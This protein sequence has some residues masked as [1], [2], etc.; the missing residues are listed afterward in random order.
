MDLVQLFRPITKWGGMIT[1]D[2]AVPEMVR[3]AFKQARTERPGAAFLILPEDVSEQETDG[4]P[5]RVNVP[6]DPALFMKPKA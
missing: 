1:V 5:L 4:V 6:V 3:K 2:E